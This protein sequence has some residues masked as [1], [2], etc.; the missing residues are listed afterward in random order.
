MRAHEAASSARRKRLERYDDHGDARELTFSCYQR[1][2]FLVRERTRQ[3][4]CDAI[5]R[6]RS[7]HPFE[8]WA[9]VVMPEHVHLLVWPTQP[10]DV[11][12]RALASIKQSVARRAVLYL[13][14]RDPDGLGWLAT[15][16][17]S[18]PLRFW[19]PGGGYD[20]NI[21]RRTTLSLVVDYIHANPVR[22]GLVQTAEEWRWSSIHEWNRQGSGPIPLDQESFP[23]M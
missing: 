1:R 15:G 19:Q 13:R 11:V 2:P 23:N 22:R 7:L 4:L 10:G 12:S 16:Q 20:R 8:L 5:A 6:A 14:R 9:Y 21:E 18:K 17:R 3:W